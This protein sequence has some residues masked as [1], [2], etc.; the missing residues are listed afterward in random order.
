M[1]DYGLLAMDK[2]NK[3]R[4]HS[5]VLSFNYSLRPIRVLSLEGKSSAIISKQENRSLKNMSSGSITD[6][7]HSLDLHV[8]PKKGWMISV[9][10]ELFDSSE[11]SIDVNYFCDLSLSYKSKSWEIA[12][13]GNN[14]FGTS[15]FERRI[16]GNTIETYSVTRLRPREFIV[17]V[18]FGN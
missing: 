15:E 9:K 7:N 5:S 8:F 14:I 1:T 12:F 10:N 17:K 2:V 18:C 3:G 4:M 16:L 13:D 11:R 6:W